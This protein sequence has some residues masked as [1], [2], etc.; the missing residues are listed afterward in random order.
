MLAQIKFFECKFVDVILEEDRLFALTTAGERLHGTHFVAHALGC[1]LAAG[2]R[3][4]I[5]L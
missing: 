3:L 4:D 5:T 2:G 1:I